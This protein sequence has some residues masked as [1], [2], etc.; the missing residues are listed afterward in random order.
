MAHRSE[1]GHL[2]VSKT[3]WNLSVC[4]F[5]INIYAFRIIPKDNG[6]P[7]CI[8]RIQQLGENKKCA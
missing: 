7:M 1:N 5:S 8:E 6:L 2:K 3:L 4:I